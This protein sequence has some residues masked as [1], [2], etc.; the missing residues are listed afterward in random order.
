MKIA[1]NG[2]GDFN[3][4]IASYLDSII[5]ER[6]T[7]LKDANLVFFDDV[8]LILEH[9]NSHD[10]HHPWHRPEKRFSERVSGA[11]DISDFVSDADYIITCVPAQKTRESFQKL[12]E[13]IPK[14]STIIIASKGIV[15]EGEEG[16]KEFKLLHDV[17]KEELEKYG[18]HNNIAVIGGGTIADDVANRELLYADI[19]SYDKQNRQNV[20][21]LFRSR[22]MNIN[23]TDNVI[24]VEI[25][26]ALKNVVSIATGMAEGFGYK[27]AIPGLMAYGEK[28]I[29][30]I[31]KAL[32]A[33]DNAGNS[34]YDAALTGDLAL[35]CMGEKKTRNRRY[36]IRLCEHD[37]TPE[38]VLKEM[39]NMTVEGYF[40]TKVAHGLVQTL[41]VK[42][43]IIEC[44]HDILYNGKKPK[45][46]L[47]QLVSKTF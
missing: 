25:A 40:T 38:T 21:N 10:R 18:K 36:G 22:T 33:K 41:E 7:W 27:S 42:A 3:S 15:S 19:A 20:A 32:G 16:N 12:A 43:P 11:S 34:A 39:K 26:S 2:F 9:F 14:K 31:A 28:E 45:R 8:P 17:V 29:K 46:R 47:Y 35:S 13:H 24:G 1:L 5:D 44:V 4:G 23:E 6:E 30:N 37:K